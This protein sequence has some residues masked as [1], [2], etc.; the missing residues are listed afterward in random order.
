MSDFRT[1]AP[2][3][4]PVTHID[5]PKVDTLKLDNGSIRHNLRAGEQDLVKLDIMFHAGLKAASK[6]LQSSMTAK[7]LTEGTQQFT[8]Q[9]LA[10]QLDYY[11]AYLHITPGYDY[12]VMSF[13][14]LSKHLDSMLPYLKSVIHEPVFPE[15]E[16]EILKTKR[17]HK[18]LED[19][20]KVSVMAQR[21]FFRNLMGPDHPYA[22]FEDIKVY[23]NI[24]RDDLIDFHQTNYRPND[25]NLIVCG[26][27]SDKALYQIDSLIG[28][29][30]WKT[31]DTA[32]NK[33]QAFEPVYG[34]EWIEKKGATQNA[35][36]LGIPLPN[37]INED[38][39]KLRV[40][41]TALG[42]YFGSRL[43]MNIRE[44]K[45]YTY[46]I[47]ASYLSFQAGGAMFIFS[48]V[49][50]H[51]C[52]PAYEEIQKEITKLKEEKMSESELHMVRSY[53]MSKI[54][55]EVDGPF[56]RANTLE[57]LIGFD[58]DWDHYKKLIHTVQTITPEE[59]QET[60]Q[61]YFDQNKQITI[62]AGQVPNI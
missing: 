32:Q 43:N 31:S 58:L 42:G 45:G 25:L 1:K 52:Q 34:T 40:V 24:Q 41:I 27:A 53:M 29:S 60:A 28:D 21:R 36:A 20:E 59:I 7:M 14:T 10:E 3:H 49:G 62:I 46:G 54:M 23:Q 61:R 8:A 11:G 35:I 37:K 56:A 44:D 4:H 6:P 57:S 47:R 18:F 55:S 15:K 38:Y 12:S 9:N 50:S 48:E 26:Q 5:L 13:L 22:P 2:I 30:T 51:V 39:F 19:S 16:F 17:Q 33:S